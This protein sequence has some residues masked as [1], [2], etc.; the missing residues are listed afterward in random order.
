M[1]LTP[2]DIHNKEFSISFRGYN[3][4]EVND[5]L[6]QIIRDFDALIR[7]NE[8]LKERVSEL[9]DRLKRF[10]NLEETLS[11]SIIVAQEAAEEVKTNARKEAELIIR[12]AEKNANHIIDEALSKS[13]KVQIEIEELKQ[14]AQVYRNRFRTLLEAQLEML[15]SHDWE[16]LSDLD[17]ED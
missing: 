4:D 3:I 11:K 16:R 13:R 9:E 8:E 12:E 15:K 2:L 17:E 7:T 1:P 5:F 14:R 10:E 6:N